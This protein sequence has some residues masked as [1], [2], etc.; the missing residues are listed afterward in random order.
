MRAFSAAKQI[1]ELTDFS[2]LVRRLANQGVI[3]Y[4]DAEN[5]IREAFFTFTDLLS[6]IGRSLALIAKEIATYYAYNM[7]FAAVTQAAV[8]GLKA[9]A[10]LVNA[11]E[12]VVGLGDE[13]HLHH[14]VFKAS[15]NQ[16]YLKVNLFQLPKAAHTKLHELIRTNSRFAKLQP[17][18]ARKMTKILEDVG[19][20]KWLDE[21]GECYKWLETQN[22]SYKGIYGAYQKA[23]KGIGGASG[24]IAIKP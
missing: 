9:S 13:T 17:G 4:L 2:N 3:D 18:G 7:A 10:K 24:L 14:L 16:K 22:S 6:E 1:L 19:K 11:T 8:G 21:L 12:I 20:Q 23:I 15:V 5:I